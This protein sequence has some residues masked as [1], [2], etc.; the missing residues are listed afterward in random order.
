MG[1]PGCPASKGTALAASDIITIQSPLTPQT[2]GMHRHA[3]VSRD[4]AQASHHQRR[5]LDE[6]LI[7]GIGFDVLQVAIR[8]PGS[9]LPGFRGRGLTPGSSETSLAI[10]ANGRAL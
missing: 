3:R 1:Q 2:R 7:S 9:P 5:A 8:P 6:G 4:E 10:I